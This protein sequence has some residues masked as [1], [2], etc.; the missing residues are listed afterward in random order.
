MDSY[1]FLAI[2]RFLHPKRLV[3]ALMSGLQLDYD[4]LMRLSLS[5]TSTVHGS[6]H[7]TVPLRPHMGRSA[8]YAI[9]PLP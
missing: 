2:R 5:R 4:S 9:Q 3:A 1:A 8:A 6:N 7:M